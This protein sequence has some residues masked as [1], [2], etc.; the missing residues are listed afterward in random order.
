MSYIEKKD[1]KVALVIAISTSII[2]GTAYVFVP[3]GV[4][5]K[6]NDKIDKIKD[7]AKDKIAR[8]LNINGHKTNDL[9][10]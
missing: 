4:K 2:L 3:R 9:S 7:S 8:F 10:K 6:M 1:F 5:D